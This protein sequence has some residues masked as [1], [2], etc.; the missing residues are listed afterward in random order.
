MKCALIITLFCNEKQSFEC[1]SFHY[2][3]PK[4]SLTN[5]SY[6]AY[7][8]KKYREKEVENNSSQCTHTSCLRS[9]QQCLILLICNNFFLLVVIDTFLLFNSFT[10]V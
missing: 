4:S 6:S 10:D 9:R 5:A 2:A 3:S 1:L 8:T 7:E